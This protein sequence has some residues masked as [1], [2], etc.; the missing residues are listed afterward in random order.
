MLPLSFQFIVKA[1]PLLLSLI[2]LTQTPALLA[3][4]IPV[5]P[6]VSGDLEIIHVQGNVWLIAGVGGNIAVQAGEQGVFVVDTG[7]NGFGEDVISA[8]AKI[9]ERPIRYIVNTSIAAQHVGGNT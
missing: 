5:E 9:S 7:A 2:C 1:R 8:I 3:Q 4:P 6:Q